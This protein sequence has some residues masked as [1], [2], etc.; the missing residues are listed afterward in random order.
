MAI[1]C[2]PELP[3]GVTGPVRSGE[4]GL[5]MSMITLPSSASPYSATAAAALQYGTA[6]ITMSPFGAAP[7]LPVVAPAASLSASARA[8]AESRLINLD[9][10]SSLGVTAARSPRSCL[11]CR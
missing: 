4:I 10:V 5:V 9:G 6:R 7:Y 11:L 8:L 1:S 3:S 2:A